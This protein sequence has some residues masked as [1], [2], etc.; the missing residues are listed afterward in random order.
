MTIKRVLFQIDE[1][2]RPDVHVE[3]DATLPAETAFRE[4]LDLG[5]AAY[6]VTGLRWPPSDRVTV[7]PVRP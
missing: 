1:G 5:G 4:V 3:L 6:Q 7:R 2:R